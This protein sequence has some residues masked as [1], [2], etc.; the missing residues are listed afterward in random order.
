MTVWFFARW[1][2]WRAAAGVC[3]FLIF[4][5]ER[6]ALSHDY[7]LM[8]DPMVV[9]RGANV[10]VQL[11]VGD[12]FVV[13]SERGF[14]RANT[15]R[16][17]HVHGEKIDDLVPS[18]VEGARPLTTLRLTDDG[19]H[20]LALDR[21]Y[22]RITLPADRF[23]KY[24]LEEKLDWAR[25]ARREHGEENIPG[26]ERYTRYVKSLIQVG[27][28]H[29]AV[30]RQSLEQTLEIIP[31]LDPT[32]VEPSTRLPVSVIFRGAPL[33]NVHLFA[34]AR[35]AEGTEE[36]EAVTDMNGIA[37]VPL[38]KRGVFLLHL[39]HMVRCQGC[40]DADWESFW[41]SYS[42]ASGTPSPHRLSVS[43]KRWWRRSPIVFRLS[44]GGAVVLAAYFWLTWRRKTAK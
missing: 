29:D 11:L 12:D 42:F 34:H 18:T 41:A 9:P 2:S 1:N 44:L 4:S 15:T 30:F 24:L 14:E 31:L 32:R 28:K 38:P 7:W 27:D 8:P 43:P 16:W 17:V 3:A 23:N 6:A 35:S 13:Q 33:P 26:R 22:A 21:G 20:L 37:Q 5:F 19:G 40:N 36:V 25:A 10:K 39:V